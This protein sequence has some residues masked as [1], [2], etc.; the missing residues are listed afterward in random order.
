MHLMTRRQ[1][2]Q[3]AGAG[4]AALVLSPLAGISAEEKQTGFTL[5]KLPYAYDALEPYIDA[6][7]MKIHHDLHHKAYV[8]SLNKALAS[9]PELLSKPIEELLRHEK[10]LPKDVQTAV[11]NFGGGHANHTMFWEIMIK[12]PGGKPSGALAEAIDK[13]LGGF[14]KFQEELKKA[15]LGRFGSGWAWLDL[16]NG[17]LSVRSLANQDSPL[18]TGRQ[19]I[20]GI[21]VWEHAY[22]LKYQNKRADYVD[23]WFNVINWENVGE[24]YNHARKQA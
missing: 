18:R 16:A 2:L 19:P 1:M 11:R 21:D 5:P 13:D 9:H 15:A 12:N 7:T 24:R 22:Y 8:D 20:L 23:A 17:K 4:A 10:E 6:R 3:T 14:A